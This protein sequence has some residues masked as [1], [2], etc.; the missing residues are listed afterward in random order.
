MRKFS[1]LI[2]LFVC[3][4]LVVPVSA[5]S[6]SWPTQAGTSGVQAVNMDP[7][8]EAH[9]VATYVAE[10]GTPYVL[11]SQTV[12]VA[13]SYTWYAMPSD[14]TSFRG[15]VTLSSDASIAA[16]A[17]T[18]WG[19]GGDVGAACYSGKSAGALLVSLPLLV[20]QHYGT[21][22]AVTVQNTDPDTATSVNIVF[23]PSGGAP[24]TRTMNIAAGASTT[25]DLAFDTDFVDPSA[26]NAGWV[27]SAM[28]KSATIPVVA[29]AHT[30]DQVNQFVYAYDGFTVLDQS[31]VFTPLV[32][33]TFYGFT[34]GIQVADTGGTG[35]TV[36]VVYSGEIWP[37]KTPYVYTDTGTLAAGGSVLFYQGSAYLNDSAQHLP[38]TFLGSA[39]ITATG[40][41]IAVVVNDQ[42]TTGASSAYSGFFAADGT[43]SLVSPLARNAFA[44][45]TTGIQVQNIG[46][47]AATL[48]VAYTTSSLSTNTTTPPSGSDRVLQPG[49]ST[50]Y[51]LPS[52]WGSTSAE[53]AWL[54]SA[55]IT[56]TGTDV[57]IVAITND[58]DTVRN[59][60]DTAIFNCP[61]N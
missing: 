37:A 55:E 58:Q 20:I 34:S 14:V 52:D 16:I 5:Q 36:Q 23:T 54:G 53:N 9:I 13:G 32:R 49:Q 33:R 39:K 28:V 8:A 29:A 51:Y 60:G 1:I 31:V 38:E 56:A 50:T 61:N 41:S 46:S 21:T 12:P 40:T 18:E 42:K 35:G 47:S 57:R 27:G 48:H 43:D 25:M 59:M 2:S 19:S 4:M 10:N 30:T 6:G 3:L 11:A 45:F 15:A 7:S 44:N 24:F 22:S 26:G 17:K